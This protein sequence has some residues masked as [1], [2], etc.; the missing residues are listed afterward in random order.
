MKPR[1]LS[2]LQIEQLQERYKTCTLKELAFEFGMTARMMQHYLGIKQ[3]ANIK[4]CALCFD[5][6]PG[7][8]V[9]NLCRKCYGII[10]RS[11]K[12][13]VSRETIEELKNDNSN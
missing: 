12:L 6:I 3:D 2:P 1:K 10:Y 13:I 4:K 7:R 5:L 11:V 9:S 8:R